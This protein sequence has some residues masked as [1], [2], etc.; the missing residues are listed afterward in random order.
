MGPAGYGSVVSAAGLEPRPLAVLAVSVLLVTD[1]PA[2][3]GVV[4]DPMP[5]GGD[6]QE[7]GQGEGR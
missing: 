4:R 2:Q 3:L 7:A 1:R 6:H 5:C